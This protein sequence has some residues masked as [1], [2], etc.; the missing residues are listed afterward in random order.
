[1]V[2]FLV[3]PPCQSQLLNLAFLRLGIG[4][5]LPRYIGT[6]EIKNNEREIKKMHGRYESAAEVYSKIKL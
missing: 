6:M 3:Y 1:M 4:R 5:Y 2:Q